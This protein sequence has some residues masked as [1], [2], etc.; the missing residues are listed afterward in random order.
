[1]A[2]VKSKKQKTT[3]IDVVLNEVQAVYF[4]Q[5]EAAILKATPGEYSRLTRAEG[6]EVLARLVDLV[7]A[8]QLA[9]TIRD[10]REGR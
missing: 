7:Y 5:A 9:D 4:R 3:R 1:M 2:R 6:V 10:V 8:D